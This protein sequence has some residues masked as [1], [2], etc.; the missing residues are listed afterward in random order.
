MNVS[1]L[2]LQAI[3]SGIMLLS[4]QRTYKGGIEKYRQCLKIFFKKIITVKDML[5]DM[6]VHAYDPTTWETEAERP[7]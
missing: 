6:V 7:L 3:N 2:K 4:P 5:P 1:G